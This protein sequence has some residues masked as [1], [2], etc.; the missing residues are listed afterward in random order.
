LPEEA[1]T[2]AIALGVCKF[3]V[4]TE[5]RAAY[6]ATLRERLGSEQKV[7][8]PDLMRDAIAAMRAVVAEKLTLFGS[9][10]RA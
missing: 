8:V 6:L 10:G 2:R 1:I 4:N 5:V 9:V 3:N 7:D